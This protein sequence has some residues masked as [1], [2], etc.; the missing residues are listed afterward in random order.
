[1]PARG[2]EFFATAYAGLRRLVHARLRDGGRNTVRDTT[3]L[4]HESYTVPGQFSLKL[5]TLLCTEREAFAGIPRTYTVCRLSKYLLTAA[6]RASG[7]LAIPMRIAGPR[8][9]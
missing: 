4:V 1:M 3:A 8:F 9:S 7:A 5:Q 6:C 2:M